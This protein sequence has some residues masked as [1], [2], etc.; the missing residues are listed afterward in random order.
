MGFGSCRDGH[1]LDTD[2]LQFVLGR[3]LGAAGESDAPP[4]PQQLYNDGTQKFRQGKLP[5]AA[6]EF[7]K[8]IESRPDLPLARFSVV[9]YWENAD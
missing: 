5:E 4:S 1:P 2:E 9:E 7:E 3:A 6:R 8:A